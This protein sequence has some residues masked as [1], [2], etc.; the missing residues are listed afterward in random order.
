M[1]K[2]KLYLDHLNRFYDAQREEEKEKKFK[3]KE[4]VVLEFERVIDF[5]Q[6][7]KERLKR[8][9]R[10]DGYCGCGTKSYYI[11]FYENIDAIKDMLPKDVSTY[12]ANC[13]F[14]KEVPEDYL[15]KPT[16]QEMFV[17]KI[18]GLISLDDDYEDYEKKNEEKNDEPDL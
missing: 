12:R 16:E 7:I 17:Y 4:I 5:E 8:L 6:S 10:I 9:V 11:N 13:L 18:H 2:S 14:Q 15:R 3:D 1:S